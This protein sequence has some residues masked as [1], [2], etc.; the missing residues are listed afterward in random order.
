MNALRLLAPKP[1]T[2]VENICSQCQTH[3][4]DQMTVLT[5]VVE[6]MRCKEFRTNRVLSK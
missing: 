1:L 2:L 3:Q 4:H 6:K 5:E